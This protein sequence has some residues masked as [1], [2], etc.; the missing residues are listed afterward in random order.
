MS[1]L[2]MGEFIENEQGRWYLSGKIGKIGTD[3]IALRGLV[4]N[5][6]AKTVDKVL[7][8]VKS[9]KDLME[10]LRK[11][12][13]IVGMAEAGACKELHSRVDYCGVLENKYG[14]KQLN[15]MVSVTARYRFKS[16]DGSFED[17]WGTGQGWDTSDKA[18][19]KASTYAWKSA[20]VQ[21]L[22]L[23]DKELVDA[24]MASTT[25]E[26]SRI[27][28]FIKRIQNGEAVRAVIA[29][30]KKLNLSKEEKDDIQ[31]AVARKGAH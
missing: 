13:D 5:L 28:P 3:L 1:D 17:Y 26:E 30:A 22:V 9:A 15:T 8:P 7:F 23:G 20:I 4:G 6:Q 16:S 19:G 25:I 14:V 21:A 31:A 27:G 24:D 29:E 10:K 12:A 2:N 18:A 11:A